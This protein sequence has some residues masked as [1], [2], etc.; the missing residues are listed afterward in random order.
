[1]D[2]FLE[3]IL[4]TYHETFTEKLVQRVHCETL[5]GGLGLTQAALREKFWVPRLCSLVKT[6]R[7]KCWAYKRFRLQAITPPIPGQLPKDR[8]TVG[9]AFE[10]IGVD[11]AGPIKYRKSSK[12][13]RKVYLAIFA[14]SLSRAVHLELLRNLGTDTLSCVWNGLSLVVDVRAWSIQIMTAR[15]SKLASG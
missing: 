5:H 8:T 2:E 15:L 10:I 3:V 9:T 13:E 4:S 14:C 1:M 11:F 7:S 6:V 12:A